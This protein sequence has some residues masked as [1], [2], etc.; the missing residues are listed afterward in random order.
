[1]LSRR[2]LRRRLDRLCRSSV[3]RAKDT[4]DV[5]RARYRDRMPLQNRVTPGG[6]LIA[7]SA[8]GT[9]MGNRGTLHDDNKAIVRTSR[10]M[11]WLIC[12][13]EFKGRK[14]PL[15]SP[16]TYTELFFLDEAV[17]LA[18]GHRPCGESR[19]AQYRAFI[20][21]VNGG[22]ETGLDGARDLDR[23]LNDSR[24]APRTA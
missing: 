6:E 22:V 11:M 21:A 2:S 17:A 15:M 8:R 3:A 10:N 13:L 12:R 19:R 1:M 4:A 14:R 7:T 9:L 5:R 18:A 24:R 20:E 16:G 23:Q